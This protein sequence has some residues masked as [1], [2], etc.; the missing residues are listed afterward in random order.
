VIPRTRNPELYRKTIAEDRAMT[1]AIAHGSLS[2]S[3]RQARLS[4]LVKRI[5]A[6]EAKT[7]A[8]SDPDV[9]V[10]RARQEMEWLRRMS[11][12]FRMR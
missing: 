4:E 2:R 1:N 10:A 9:V 6:A 7:V 11:E 3:A 8:A 5:R 12:H